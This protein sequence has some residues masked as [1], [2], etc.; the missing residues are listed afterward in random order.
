M[1]IVDRRASLW[2]EQQH[3]PFICAYCNASMADKGVLCVICNSVRYCSLSHR[4]AHQGAHREACSALQQL[5]KQNRGLQRGPAPTSR[6]RLP[7]GG[8]TVASDSFD[9]SL[10]ET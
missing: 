3:I 8:S 6:P 7:N 5:S 4:N 9:G 1:P 2:V 10:S